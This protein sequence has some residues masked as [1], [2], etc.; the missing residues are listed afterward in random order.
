LPIGV[1]I[2]GANTHDQKLFHET[3]ASIPITRPRPTRR[4]RHH[5][6]CD[7]GYDCEMLRQDARWCGY[8][9]HINS[10]RDERD[11]RRIGRQR[12]R[13]WVVERTASWLNR[14]RRILIRWEKKADNYLGLL[15]LVFAL[16]LW[17]NC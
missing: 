9:P 10:W 7:L 3:L 12:A 17:R 5:L 4:H 14:Y 8:I 2:A 16:T 11:K 15:H 6:C 13:R 1:A